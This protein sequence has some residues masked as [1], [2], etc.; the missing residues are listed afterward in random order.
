MM[1]AATI[2]E[3]AQANTCHITI[4]EKNA[5]LGK[6]VALSGGGRS[7]IT[8]GITDRATLLSKYVRGS[9]L[10]KSSL[11]AFSP[12]KVREWF[13][14]HGVLTKCEED[15]RVFPVSDR[16]QDSVDVFLKVFDMHQRGI[17]IRYQTAISAVSL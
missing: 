8:T 5:V 17:E 6:K 9:E 13:D 15:L 4:F 16:G 3:S 10:I 1:C 11:G 7:N 14:S 12:K 2:L